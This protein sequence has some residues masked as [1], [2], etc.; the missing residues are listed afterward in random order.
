MKVSVVKTIAIATTALISGA[1][2]LVSNDA[3]A[4]SKPAERWFEIELIV[5]SPGQSTELKEQ[6]DREVKP[7]RL[8]NSVDLVSARYQ[9]EIRPLLLALTDCDA[10]TNT[11]RRFLPAPLRNWQ[12]WQPPY[13]A[14]FCISETEPAAW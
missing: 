8:G 12:Q 2:L 6:F 10:N 11:R 4:S 9:P 13:A 7:I 5:F 1:L 14:L 3:G